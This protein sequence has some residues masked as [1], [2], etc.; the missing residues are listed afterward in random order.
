VKRKN[1]PNETNA[2]MAE[3]RL[4]IDFHSLSAAALNKTIEMVMAAKRD[5]TVYVSATN[6]DCKRNIQ[7]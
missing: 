1:P 4:V 3:I 2:K 6:W 7:F 5:M